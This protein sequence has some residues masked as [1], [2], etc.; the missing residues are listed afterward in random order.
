MN[1]AFS[2]LSDMAL[3]GEKRSGAN[4]K[5]SDLE[6]NL[7]QAFDILKEMGMSKRDASQSSVGGR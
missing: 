3:H 5:L 7:A 1:D 6:G 2:I 4:A